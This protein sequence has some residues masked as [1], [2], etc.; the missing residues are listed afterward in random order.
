MSSEVSDR[1]V[2]ISVADQPGSRCED[3]IKVE[4]AN[5]AGVRNPHDDQYRVKM[6]SVGI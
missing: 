1:T 6:V 5:P 2:K 3:L 4:K